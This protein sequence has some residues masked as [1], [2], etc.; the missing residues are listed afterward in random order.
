MEHEGIKIPILSDEDRK[1][2]KQYEVFVPIKWD[3][4]RIAIPSTYILDKN[5][6]IC[7]SYIG[8]S[9][10]DRPAIE[11]ILT[12]V[13]EIK[14]SNQENELSDNNR[15]STVFVEAL[16]ETFYDINLSTQTIKNSVNHNFTSIYQLEN[17]FV[18]NTNDLSQFFTVFESMES[19]INTYTDKIHHVVEESIEII[20]DNKQA[21]SH[22]VETSNLLKELVN[23]TQTVGTISSTISGIAAQ[24]KIL[25]L[26]ASIEAARAGEQGKGF[27]VV[28]QEVGKLA[29]ASAEASQKISDQLDGIEDKI[30]KSFSSFNDFDHVMHKMNTKVQD[31]NEEL[32]FVSEGILSIQ[33]ESGELANRLKL[34]TNQQ[35]EAA[36]QLK[37]IKEQEN[38]ISTEI[39]GIYQDIQENNKLLLELDKR[40]S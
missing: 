15:D 17:E 29:T 7:Y 12:K 4:F 10:F 24:T 33:S 18:G 13:Q 26:N 25:A 34:I 36:K 30:N 9:Q 32:K 22:M 14:P 39:E 40:L 27:S 6:T 20:N 8:D 5:H 3:S 37:S 31:Q 11:D 23:L 2:I 1:V 19:K 38:T 21:T 28:A 35:E 16:K